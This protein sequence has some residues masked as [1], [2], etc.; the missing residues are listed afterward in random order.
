MG[1]CGG[2][3]WAMWIVYNRRSRCQDEQGVALG[4][5]VYGLE[6]YMTV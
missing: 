4:R 5:Q 6:S 2:E 3:R 1:R